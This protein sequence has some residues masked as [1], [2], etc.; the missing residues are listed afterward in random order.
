MLQSVVSLGKSNPRDIQVEHLA[1]SIGL[2]YRR[3]QKTEFLT[4]FNDWLSEL[5]PDLLFV[6]GCQF[7]IH[8]YLFSIP[9]KG[10]YNIHFSL[11]P[12]YRGRNPIFWQLKN[13]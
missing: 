2:P 7:T 6:F 9:K 11:L 10:V 8:V 3:F 5:Q 4:S 12:A 1:T 13:G